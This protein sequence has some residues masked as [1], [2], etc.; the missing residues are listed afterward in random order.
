[1]PRKSPDGRD[2]LTW[3]T[4]ELT[5]LGEQKVVEGTIEVA[6]RHDLGVDDTFPVFVPATTYRKSGKVITLQLMQGYVFVA[7]GLPEVS[8]F[9]LERKPYVAGVLSTLAVGNRVRTLRVLPDL[10]IRNLRKRMTEMVSSDIEVGALVHVVSGKYRGMD[11]QVLE[12]DG[13]VAHVEF[14]LRSLWRISRIPTIFLV[15]GEEF[16][17]GGS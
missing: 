14:R 2:D 17:Y 16:D 9:A 11:G 15:V 7:S 5:P 3:I 10:E 13:L 1:M 8:Y 12:V 6:L 4:V